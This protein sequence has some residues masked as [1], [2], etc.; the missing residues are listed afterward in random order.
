MTGPHGVVQALTFE[1]PGF[2]RYQVRILVGTAMEVGLGRR[3]V[4]SI[5]DLLARG[6]EGARDEAGRTAP[7]DGLY[8]VSV[9]YEPR[10]RGVLG[11]GLPPSS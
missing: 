9:G 4:A 2:L 5:P 11:Q 1:G 3:P 10:E 8:L 7:P 6:P